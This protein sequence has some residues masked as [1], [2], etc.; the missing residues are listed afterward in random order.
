MNAT[1]ILIMLGTI[2]CLN[3]AIFFMFAILHG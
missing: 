3:G 2:C 1:D